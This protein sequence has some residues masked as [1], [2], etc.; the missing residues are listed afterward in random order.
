LESIFETRVYSEN[1]LQEHEF[2]RNPSPEEPAMAED[3]DR[4]AGREFA[5]ECRIYIPSTRCLLHQMEK[6]PER[7]FQG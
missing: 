4:P 5:P 2:Y 3:T 7:G 6:L 1:L